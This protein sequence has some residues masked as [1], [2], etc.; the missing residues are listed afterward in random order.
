MVVASAKRIPIRERLLQAPS[1]QRG[2]VVY[3]DHQAIA[4][5]GAI[6]V[7]VGAATLPGGN[8]I[9]AGGGPACVYRATDLNADDPLQ[10]D[11]TLLKTL[12]PA[13]RTLGCVEQD[14]LL[15]RHAATRMDVRF[16][17]REAYLVDCAAGT[18]LL[19]GIGRHR[20]ALAL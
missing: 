14:G 15:D 3:A 12:G 19:T 4:G 18:A 5:T 2:S 13:H 11:A 8:E 9:S 10:C 20:V 7:G 1:R 17:G 6:T 16:T